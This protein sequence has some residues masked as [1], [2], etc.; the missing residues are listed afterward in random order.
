MTPDAK[1]EAGAA[2]C[3]V[4]SG[5]ASATAAMLY[6]LRE[7]S[8]SVVAASGVGLVGFVVGFFYPI[9]PV[10]LAIAYGLKVYVVQ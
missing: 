1:N 7:H 3:G 4:V 2:C 5:L 8:Y 6:V 9:M 10:L